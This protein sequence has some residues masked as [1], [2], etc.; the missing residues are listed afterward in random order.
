MKTL[1]IV[2]I[3]NRQYLAGAQ[4][5]LQ[6]IIDSYPGPERLRFYVFHVKNHLPR[7]AIQEFKDYFQDSNVDVEFVTSPDI[8]SGP[9]RDAFDRYDAKCDDIVAKHPGVWAPFRSLTFLKAWLAD[10]LPGESE[11]VFID[12]D[13]FV[14]G[15]IRRLFEFKRTRAIAAAYDNWP[16]GWTMWFNDDLADEIP[17]LHL[18]EEMGH[19]QGYFNTG[20]FI[21]DLDRWRSMD[22]QSQVRVLMDRYF[23]TYAEQDA[24]NH[25]LLTDKDTLPPHFNAFFGSL[26]AFPFEAR[27]GMIKYDTE[28]G[29]PVIVHFNGCFK[30]IHKRFNDYVL[31]DNVYGPGCVANELPPEIAN[32]PI[33]RRYNN[34]KR[35]V[36][37]RE[38]YRELLDRE[39]DSGSWQSL[40]ESPI[41][42]EDIKKQ[43]IR[44]DEY[45]GRNR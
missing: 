7:E 10:A 40:I 18:H 44:S 23:V 27:L 9:T 5:L 35:K 42:I 31:P 25:L 28:P 1:P 38:L 41:A 20:V 2:T 17:F 13:A 21:A 6:S 37:I 26:V 45:R 39:P 8:E 14:F 11:V 12:A 3:A 32:D 30:P 34:I 29:R 43:I 24:L 33:F 19:Y 16:S 22:L 4:F 36:M 15:D